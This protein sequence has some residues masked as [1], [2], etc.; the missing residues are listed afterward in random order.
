MTIREILAKREAIRVELRAIQAA[1]PDALPEAQQT[2]WTELEGQAAALNLQEGRQAMI[3]DLD[4]RAAGTT[5][6]G[7]GDNRLDTQAA[8]VNI[9]DVVRAQLGAT[10]AGAGRAREVSAELAR[11]SGRQPEGLLF[12]MGVSGAPVENRTFSTFAPAG[13]PGS[14]L[15]Q[16]TISPN[17][18]DRLRE[19]VMVRRMGATVLGGLVGNLSIPRLKASASAQWVAE[20][21]PLSASTPQVDQVTLTPKHCGGIVELSRQILQQSSPDVQRLVEN[22]LASLLAVALDQVAIQG[23]GPNQPSG[24]LAAG[25][26]VTIV[27]GGTNGAAP[28]WGNIISLIA[29]L[30]QANALDGSLGFLTNAK[31]VRAMRQTPRTA[32]DTASNFIMNDPGMLAG[33]TLGSTQNVPS[34]GTK[35]TGTGLSSLI[36][37]DWSSL[38][39]GFWSE[40]DILTS[41]YSA[42]AFERGNIQVRAMMTADVKLRHPEAFAAITDLIA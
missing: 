36:F 41:P 25:S 9:L 23:G 1:H 24:I 16:T 26:G 11:R 13:G 40:L 28:T 29:A 30:D 18:I 15:V 27:P 19:R 34:T 20:D 7:T 22:D 8:Q 12:H 38:F 2:R 6:A 35:G 10:D 3:D 42:G 21:S 4:R 31:A 14:N 39:L 32:A 5:I 33:Y 17:L 37:G